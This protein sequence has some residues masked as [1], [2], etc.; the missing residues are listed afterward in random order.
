[1]GSKLTLPERADVTGHA[2][3]PAQPEK[4][5]YEALERAW[6]ALRSSHAARVR[7]VACAGAPRTLLMAEFGPAGAPSVSISAGVHGD[8][9]AAP[10][11]LLSIVRDGLLDPRFAYR[12]W[13]CTNPTGYQLGTRANAEGDDINRSFS[14]G[15]TTPE[16][17]AIVTATRDRRFVLSLDLHEDYEADGFYLYEPVV[18]DTLALGPEIIAALDDA[19]LPVQERVTELDL[20]YPEAAGYYPR[21]ERGRVLP[22]IEEE[23]ALFKGL[24]YS[25]HLV[26]RAADRV[27]TFETPRRLAW[28]VRIAMSRVAVVAALKQ[29]KS[30][31]AIDG[32]A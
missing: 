26:R 12:I 2:A 31:G 1:M 7:E 21:S 20:G 28:D 9:P 16:S 15:G 11:A 18:S 22:D 10:W 4:R 32:A 27:M 23:I 14:R 5:E 30:N 6:K 8:E 25:L 29:L 19:G 3:D 13:P 17:R 24:P